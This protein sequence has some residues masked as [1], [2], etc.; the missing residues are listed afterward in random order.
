MG[1]RLNSHSLRSEEDTR[2]L[3]CTYLSQEPRQT[4][5]LFKITP[6]SA[7]NCAIPRQVFLLGKRWVEDLDSVAA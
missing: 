5:L 2:R 7:N 4:L 3:H 6:G 1:W